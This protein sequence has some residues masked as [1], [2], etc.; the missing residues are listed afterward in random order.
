MNLRP[1]C[2]PIE[3]QGRIGLCTAQAAVGLVE[4]FEQ[5]AFGTH[6]DASRLFIYKTTRNL[7]H[8]HGD[9]GAYLRTTMGALALFGAPPEKYWPYTDDPTD[10][11]LERT[12]FCYA[13]AQ[14]Y[15]AIRYY[16][17]DPPGVSPAALLNSVKMWLAA[18]LP[19]MFG[20]TVYSSYEQAGSTGKIPMPTRQEQNVGGHAVVVVGYDDNM[21]IKNN[22]PE[23][24]ETVGALLIRNSWGKQWGD[25][26][27]GW[28][29]YDYVL[30]RLA[31][32]WWSLIK[33]E[34]VDTRHFGF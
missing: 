24:D 22:N 12:P 20:F 10:F 19:S 17:L 33:T 27:Y 4:Y 29:P 16:R 21:H 11:N 23:V 30:Q 25:Y 15:R 2:S 6:K 26:G 8:F 28:L 34:W 9:T 18:G 14:H 31:V 1:W 3:D 13:F 7:L 32:D 5:R